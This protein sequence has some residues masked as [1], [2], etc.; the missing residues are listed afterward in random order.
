MI[1]AKLFYLRDKEVERNPK[2]AK[3]SKIKE[4]RLYDDFDPKSIKIKK[5]LPFDFKQKLIELLKKYH[6]CFPSL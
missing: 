5:K 6:E 1:I 2:L 4:V 3:E